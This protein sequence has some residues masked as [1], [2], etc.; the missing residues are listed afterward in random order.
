MKQIQWT[1][2]EQKAK[3]LKTERALKVAEVCEFSAIYLCVIVAMFQL[4]AW[5]KNVG[6]HYLSLLFLGRDDEGKV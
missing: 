4:D 2:D 1:N 6:T 5:F 3:I